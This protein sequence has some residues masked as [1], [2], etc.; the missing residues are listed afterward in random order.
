MDLPQELGNGTNSQMK[1]NKFGWTFTKTIPA[2]NLRIS[3]FRQSPK[4]YR[5]AENIGPKV[6]HTNFHSLLLYQGG[7]QEY[8]PTQDNSIPYQAG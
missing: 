7:N 2:E 5:E 8:Q 4:H 6:L 1:W 3:I